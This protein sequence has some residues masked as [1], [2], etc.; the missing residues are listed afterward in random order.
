MPPAREVG[1][2][3]YDFF[4]L[5]HGILALAIGDVSGK[6]VPASLL[7]ASLQASLRGQLS[8]VPPISIA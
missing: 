6:G 2:D 7:M 8:P 1:G 4:T 5:P 3:Y